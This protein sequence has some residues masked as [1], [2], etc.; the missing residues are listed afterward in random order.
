MVPF[1]ALLVPVATENGVCCRNFEVE[2]HHFPLAVSVTRRQIFLG[3]ERNNEVLQARGE[4][5]SGIA[6]AYAAQALCLPA[7]A[8]TERWSA[9]A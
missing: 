5:A 6:G 3:L 2:L 8:T 9:S 4:G 7:Y 1:P